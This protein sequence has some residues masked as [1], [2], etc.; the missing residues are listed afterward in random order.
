M[1]VGDGKRRCQSD[2]GKPV[3]NLGPWLFFLPEMKSVSG[4]QEGTE[5][6]LFRKIAHPDSGKFDSL[7]VGR[8]SAR[9]MGGPR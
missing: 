2:R 8:S 3:A 9:C 4:K 7:A 1:C 5:I 6:I